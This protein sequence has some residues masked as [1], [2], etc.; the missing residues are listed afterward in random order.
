VIALFVLQ[1]SQV[2]ADEAGRADPT[3]AVGVLKATA[4]P[5]RTG[6]GLVRGLVVG[7]AD[8]VQA[9]RGIPYAAPPVSSLRW[10]PPQ[11]AREWQGVR[12]CFDFAPAA[13]QKSNSLMTM[14]PGMALRAPISEDCLYLNVWAPTRTSSKPRPVMVWIH[15]GG[16]LFG[17][18]S[19]G[20]YDG[21]N[22][23]RR[24]VVVVSMNYRLGPLGF[25]AHPQLSA[26]SG[27]GYSGNY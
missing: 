13:P 26:E 11:P 3:P 18:A 17:A 5:V 6:L 20:L 2:E 14:F 7:D 8:D 25:L 10:R 22:L 16:Y 24:G 23:A 27:H 21:A 19:Q 4:K 15:G 1:V 12:E 9:Y